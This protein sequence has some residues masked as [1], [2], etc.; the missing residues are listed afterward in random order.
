MRGELLYRAHRL[1]DR[2]HHTIESAYL[3][4]GALLMLLA[5]VIFYLVLLAEKQ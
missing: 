2:V 1:S 3:H 4:A 5:L